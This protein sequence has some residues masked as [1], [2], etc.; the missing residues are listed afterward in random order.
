M[1]MASGETMYFNMICEEIGVF[2]G[3][4][5]HIDKILGSK[6]EVHEFFWE[7]VFKY[8]NAKWEIYLNGVTIL[9][10]DVK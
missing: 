4:V 10:R 1:M 2:G 7:N 8:P 3:K 5:I 9:T 6:E